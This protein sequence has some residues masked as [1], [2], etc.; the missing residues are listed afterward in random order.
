MDGKNHTAPCPLA[1]VVGQI[2]ADPTM[3]EE[4]VKV[5]R[6]MARRVRRF[7]RVSSYISL[8][9]FTGLTVVLI[10]ARVFN[11]TLFGG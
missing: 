6:S 4:V 3:P 9:V 10:M 2:K 7:A 11:V 1:L 8:V 5:A